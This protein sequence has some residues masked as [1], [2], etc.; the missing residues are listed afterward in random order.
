[1]N[2]TMSMSLVFFQNSSLGISATEVQIQEVFAE[3][4]DECSMRSNVNMEE[5]EG[6][7]K[8]KLS[9]DSHAVF[10]NNLAIVNGIQNFR[11]TIFST[12]RV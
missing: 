6:G 2:L 1:M 10:L 11:F 3:K 12:E 9:E 4:G 8:R 5:Q 7:K